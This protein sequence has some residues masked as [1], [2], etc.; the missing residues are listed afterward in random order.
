M[1]DFF[2]NDM[3]VLSKLFAVKRTASGE[4]NILCQERIYRA[5]E[6]M[7]PFVLRRR[8]DDVLKELPKKLFS[9]ERCEPTET[10]K[11]L[12]QKVLADS[13]KD[14]IEA[15]SPKKKKGD[16]APM[17]RI[18]NVMMR[19]RKAANHP[20][21]MRQLYSDTIL[22]KLS[23]QIMREPEY[24]DANREYIFED[25]QVHDILPNISTC[26][27]SSCMSF[28]CDSHLLKSMHFPPQNG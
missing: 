24:C 7:K 14:F 9:I 11:A 21:L 20:L 13:K 16:A 27:I 10:Q 28:A 17:K 8:K 26:P 5:K 4:G 3:Q 25:M 6:M 1:P 18:S 22:K 15:I 2:S 19:L 12:Y 23:K